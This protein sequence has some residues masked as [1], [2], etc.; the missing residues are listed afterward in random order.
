MQ[1]ESL[2]TEVLGQ[3]LQKMSSA[4]IELEQ[5]RVADEKRKLEEARLVC[6]RLMF[7]MSL[8]F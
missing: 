1:V 8:F 3:M 6:K 2:V 5:E 7:R 4:E